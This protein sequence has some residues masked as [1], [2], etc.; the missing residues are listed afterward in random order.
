VPYDA[1]CFDMDGVLL[2]GSHTDRSVYRQAAA[3]T[4]ADFGAEYDGQPPMDLVDPDTVADVRAMCDEL[5]IPPAAVWAYRERA[6]TT[7]ENERI[8]AGDRTPF[9][10]TPALDSL[11]CPVGVV[12]NN[13]HGT[14]RFVVE[15]FGLPASVVRG[16]FPT[17][18]EFGR[19]K[20]DP[21][22]LSWVL[23]RLDAADVLFVGDRLSDVAAA[24]RAGVDAA[25][26]TRGGE[27]PSG[28][29]EPEH[30]VDSLEA[31]L[32]IQ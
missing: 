27:P 5:E 29:H 12:S 4:L 30:H 7:V 9:Q 32:D 16:R 23:D 19:L 8:V 28:K 22:L 11:D 26:L 2:T 25:L 10:D 1:I 20:P 15:H 17:L 3:A 21:H 18:D 13:R 14:V 24:H 31:V 6:A